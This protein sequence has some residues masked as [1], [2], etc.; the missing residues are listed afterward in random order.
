MARRLAIR[1]GSMSTCVF[2]G[3]SADEAVGR[4]VMADRTA[5]AHSKAGEAAPIREDAARCTRHDLGPGDGRKESQWSVNSL[6]LD[7]SVVG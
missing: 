7:P 5:E 6:I 4:L 1:H 2:R 3:A